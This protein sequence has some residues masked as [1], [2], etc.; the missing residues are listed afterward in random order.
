M[1]RLALLFCFLVCCV[2]LS[3]AQQTV[4][5]T[6][7]DN[8]G[9][10][11]IGVNVIAKGTSV[12]TITDI[13]GNF[14]IEVPE[15]VDMVTVS[16]TG[17]ATQEVS[18]AGLSSIVVT[19]SE[20]AILDE[21]VVT[22]TGLERNKR[23]LGYAVQNV[24]PDDLIS[25]Q[26]VNFVDA[27]NSKVAGV[28]VVSSSGSP[29]ASSNIRIRGSVSINGSN[30]PLFVVDGVPID[31]S[32][33]GTGADPGSSNVSGVDYSNRA[34]DINPN[35][36]ESLTVLKGAAATA[37][38]GV[39]AANGAIV[40]TTKRGTTGKPKV[41]VSASYG[42]DQANQ[43]PARQ[44]IYAQGRPVGGVPTWRGP[45]TFE[46]FSWGPAISGLEFDGNEDYPYDSRGSL[47]PTGEGSGQAAEAYDPYD[48]F[49]N[50]NTYDLNANVSGGSEAFKYFMSFGRLSQDG[51]VPNSEF[52]RNSFRL[53]TN[54]AVTD[55]FDVGLDINYINSGGTRL[56]RGSN[57]RG[58]ML[59]LL[60]NTPT[61]DVGNG[62][63]G[64]EAADEVSTY[65]LANGDQR[66]YRAGIYDNPYW[67]VNKN[68]SF[69][70][71]NRVIGNVNLGYD[72][73]PTLRLG[74]KLGL[75]T[76]SDRRLDTEDIV[77]GWTVGSVAQHD[78]SNRD[79]NSD[80]TL[81]FNDQLSDKFGISALAG[82]NAYDT[83]FYQRSTR[84]T[85]LSSPNF[86][87]ISNATDI[88]GS[89]EILRKRIM[90]VYGTVDFNFSEYLF[91]NLT[92]RN[93][94]S[95]TLPAANNTYQSY[96]ASLGFA[97]SEL[98]DLSSSFFN[99]GKL[100]LSAG[101]VG[102]DA[103]V[104]ATNNVFLLASSATDAGIGGDG[105]ITS[106]DFPAFGT[107]AYERDI[108]LGN[109][110]IVPES[111]TSYEIG[112]EFKFLNDRLGVDV[113]YF[114]AE[115]SDVIIAVEI[116]PTTGYTNAVENAAVITNA[117]WEVS[118]YAN[119]VRV[120]D[121]RWDTEVN[122]TAME[123]TV[124][125]LKDDLENDFLAG[126]TSTSARAVAGQPYS[127]IYGLG[128]QR[129]DDNQI[130]VGNDGWPLVDPTPKALADPNPD[131]TAGWRN[132][133]TYKGV[134]LS[135]LLDIRQGG[136]VWCGTCG[137]I[138]YFG[139]SELSAEERDDVVVFNGV[140]NTGTADEPVY[141]ANTT[142]VALADP[143]SPNGVGDYY[144][145]RYGFGGIG[146]MNI[147]DASWVRLRELTLGFSLPT[148]A[149]GNSGIEGVDITLSGRNLWLKT[150]Y[151]GIDPETNLTGDTNG[152][153]LDYFNNPNTKSY[154][155]TVKLSF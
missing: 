83:R 34:I 36:V 31:N 18:V 124:E 61:F 42:L 98:M 125:S 94:W 78:L 108:L 128:F 130:I 79:L 16:Y 81:S 147:F 70:N 19:L 46:G 17:F 133:F 100:R 115:S 5:G 7:T 104:Y 107:S 43:L 2:T 53:N 102:L 99:Y 39:R 58:V 44:S 114:N 117:G 97:F 8:D 56:Q 22:A 112:G 87:H 121:F 20:G 135:G 9:M 41:T 66:S 77:P 10:P 71:V 141:E 144:R 119:P 28:S 116:S 129:T 55:K 138:N 148:S 111:T 90:G 96:S 50:G 127:A 52:N 4:T 93:D 149:L 139:T 113:N 120:G 136:S 82:F 45:E 123:N 14:A 54:S 118:A 64:Q 92:A 30:S 25:S 154:N 131:W 151:P 91:L 84:G 69:D 74:Y 48:F 146:E 12:G 27:L 11:L 57:L 65:E 95:S 75:D 86:Y 1:K 68:Q 67:V 13:D 76:Y 63:S 103:F 152:Y 62:L 47:V 80:L 40:I 72:L 88:Q 21:V 142:P 6:I 101:K 33:V 38:Y 122:F 137:I 134:T 32:S 49:V 89:E 106:F 24:D 60:R 37:L 109:N 140:V 59:G 29:G 15:G 26:E 155:A 126:F 132:S 145:V 105:F 35:D 110:L 143:S 150:E 85:T 3:M 23:T 51:I 153:G 73:T